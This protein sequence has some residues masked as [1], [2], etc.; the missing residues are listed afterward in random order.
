MLIERGGLLG[1]LVVVCAVRASG[2]F[3]LSARTKPTLAYST[4]ADQELIE[5][6]ELRGDMVVAWWRTP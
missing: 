4:S 1:D 6:R 3:P 5:R 2:K